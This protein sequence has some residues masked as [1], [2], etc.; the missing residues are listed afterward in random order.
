MPVVLDNAF[1]SH[2]SL[3][4]GFLLCM[5]RCK[6]KLSSQLAALRYREAD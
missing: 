3:M 6:S 2:P 4:L 5:H 1:C